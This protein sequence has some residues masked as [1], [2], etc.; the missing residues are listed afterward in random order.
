MSA[1]LLRLARSPAWPM[2]EAPFS[3]G[4]WAAALGVMTAT[5]TT[6]MAVNPFVPFKETHPYLGA[7]GMAACVKLTGSSLRITYDPGFDREQ[8]SVF[9]QNHVSML[10]GHV[11]C[12]VVPHAFCG[13]M[14]HW[15]FHVPGYGWI[16]RMANGIQVFPKDAGRTQEIT[17]AAKARVAEG[18]SILAFPEAHRTRD[19]HVQAYRRGVFFM[20]RDAGIPV[21]PVAVRGLYHVNHKGEWRFRPGVIDVYVGPQ[22]PV[23]GLEDDGVS[24]LAARMQAFNARWVDEGRADVALLDGGGTP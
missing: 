8:R 6:A 18:I 14:N 1:H 16:M 3:V 4:V 21:V 2:L 24:A 7:R 5:A 10:D 22:Q 9:C 17:D 19:G 13:L 15:H 12:A 20:A 23:L 11:A